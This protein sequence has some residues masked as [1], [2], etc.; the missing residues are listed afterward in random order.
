M[1]FTLSENKEN[2]RQTTILKIIATAVIEKRIYISSRS[3]P[4]LCQSNIKNVQ[5]NWA[6]LHIQLSKKWTD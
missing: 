1:E 3:V 2:L 6:I 4:I 5:Y